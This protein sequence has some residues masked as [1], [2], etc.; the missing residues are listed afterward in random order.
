MSRIQHLR[1]PISTWQ[2]DTPLFHT[3]LT[4][5]NAPESMTIVLQRLYGLS[6]PG[7]GALGGLRYYSVSHEQAPS[8]PALFR[9]A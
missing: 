1:N 4:M 6:V 8:L 9:S 3:P 2:D 7:T 5:S